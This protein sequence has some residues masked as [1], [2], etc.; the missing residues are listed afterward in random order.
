MKNRGLLH[1]PPPQSEIRL[2]SSLVERYQ[3][4]SRD[5][6]PYLPLFETQLGG[7]YDTMACVTFSALNCLEIMRN[8]YGLSGLNFSDRFTAKMS[9]TT[10]NGNYLWKVAESIKR[11]GLIGE[12][13]WPNEAAT[14]SEYYKEI[15]QNLKED[16]KG[17]FEAHKIESEY[18][19]ADPETMWKALA[20]APLQIAILAYSAPVNGISPRIQGNP[21][22]AVTIVNGE[23]GKYWQ[24]FD[25]YNEQNPVAHKIAWD[26]LIWGSTL[27]DINTTTMKLKDNTLVFLAD[28]PGGYYLYLDEKLLKMKTFEHGLTW[29]MRAVSAPEGLEGLTQTVTRADVAGI[30]VH[31]FKGEQLPDLA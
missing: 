26:Y 9:G 27:Y 19:P 8:F 29:L 14:R 28:S 13:L 2:G 12:P 22:H 31:S 17:I 10:V 3:L 18:V 5:W 23:Y 1:S 7:N 20:I 30:P 6:R 15:P 11:D 25:H 21:N 24:I 4:E 16:A